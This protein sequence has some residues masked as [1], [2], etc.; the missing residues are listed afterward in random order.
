MQVGRLQ[1]L[2][3]LVPNQRAQ[4]E[5]HGPTNSGANAIEIA[6]SGTYRVSGMVVVGGVPK[7]THLTVEI[8]QNN[9]TLLTACDTVEGRGGHAATEQLLELTADDTL[10]LWPKRILTRWSFPPNAAMAPSSI[11]AS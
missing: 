8:R 4:I 7:G 6:D 3:A 5:I 9:T 1:H 11:P 2:Q 10:T